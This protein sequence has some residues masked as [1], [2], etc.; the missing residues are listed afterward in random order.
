MNLVLR[1]Q[2]NFVRCTTPPPTKC[3]KFINFL[4]YRATEILVVLYAC[5]YAKYTTCV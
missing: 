3:I 1:T 5:I 4:K 2:N